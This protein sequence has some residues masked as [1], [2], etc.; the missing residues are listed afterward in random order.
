M[1][2][3][4][5]EGKPIGVAIAGLGTVGAGVVKILSQ[6]ADMLA[7]RAGRRLEIRAV[8]ARNREQERGIDI[9]GYKW[10]DNCLD[11]AEL[12]DVDIVIELIG[13]SHG[14]AKALVE[15]AL[16][17]GKHV[18][19]ANKALLAHH[20][21]E[22]ASMAEEK[23]VALSFEASVAGGVPVIKGLREGLAGND[24]QRIVAILNG[25]C[26]FVLGLMEDEGMA[27]EDAV[28]FAQEE[29]FAEAD[30]TVDIGGFDAAHKLAILSSIAFGTRVDAD[31]VATEGIEGIA[32]EDIAMALELGYRIKLLAVAT[33]QNGSF[34]QRVQ[35]ALVRLEHP[36]AHIS[37]PGNAILLEGDAV[38]GVEFGGPGAGQGPTASAVVADI[39]DIAR[40]IVIP[41]F[42]VPAA[43]LVPAP[44]ATPDDEMAAYYLRLMLPDKTGAIATIAS[45][46]AA[47]DISIETMIQRPEE[48]HISGAVMPVV[49]VSYLART[50]AMR[51]AVAAIEAAGIL[52][53]PPHVIRVEPL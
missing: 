50:A 46:L 32:A 28:R 14:T 49:M 20:G 6:Q 18:I 53:A 37:G 17:N 23:G 51:Q 7:Q 24:V 39:I 43:E 38:G 35:P 13:G 22:L 5:V 25:T 2:A 27:F 8:S 19:T 12:E 45:L 52:A 9:S 34:V 10:F 1:S 42:G 26:N 44:E 47:E 41:A 36:L 4:K 3:G 48:D 15:A 29:G 40:G 33:R 11:M 31:A 21:S 30:P 16:A